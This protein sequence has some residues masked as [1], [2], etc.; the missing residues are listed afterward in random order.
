[1]KKKTDLVSKLTVVY[2]DLSAINIPKLN[3]VDK[4]F[5]KGMDKEIV[6]LGKKQVKKK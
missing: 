1:M 3:K 5:P 6:R 2:E 4:S